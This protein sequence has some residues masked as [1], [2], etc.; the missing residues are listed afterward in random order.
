M[1]FFNN[2]TQKSQQIWK[3]EKDSQ[4][5]MDDNKTMS[6][7]LKLLI[8]VFLDVLSLSGLLLLLLKCIVVLGYC[9]SN[10]TGLNDGWMLCGINYPDSK[11]HGA[12]MEPIWGRQDPGGS[13][14]GPMNIVIWVLK[15]GY[16]SGHGTGAVLLP[17]SAI[18]W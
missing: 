18:N 14:V 6:Y 2:D 15:L 7:H 17:G 13:H 3:P 9:Q 12:N 4:T 11:V 5:E 10:N 16:K 1:K 8:I